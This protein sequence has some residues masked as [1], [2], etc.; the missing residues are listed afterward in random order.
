[1]GHREALGI[2]LALAAG[3]AFIAAGA[4][5]WAQA[6]WWRAAAVTGASVSLL[7][8]VV[9]FQPLIL[10]GMALDVAVLVAVVWFEWPPKAM[11]GA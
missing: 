2:A 9:F 8:F 1:L 7:F 4:R 5:L 11:V 10:F 3:A 6:K